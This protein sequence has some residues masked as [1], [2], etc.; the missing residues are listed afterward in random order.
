MHFG[1][2][3]VQIEIFKTS[4]N[5]GR[6]KNIKWI[7]HN[8]S[9]GLYIW[10]EEEWQVASLTDDNQHNKICILLCE[11][12]D[13]MSA[14]TLP[15]FVRQDSLLR[16]SVL[17]YIPITELTYWIILWS[18]GW[19]R[20]QLI[21]LDHGLYRELDNSTRINYASLWKVTMLIQLL[22]WSQFTSQYFNIFYH[23]CL[24]QALV[25]SDEKAIKEYSVKLGAGEDLHAFF[26]G[27]LT[28]K[29]WNSVIDPSVG[30]LILDGNNTDRSEVQVIFV[31]HYFL[32]T[33]GTYTSA[34]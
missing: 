34:N 16:C 18:V 29:P 26:A 17:L 23:V 15:I 10:W 22:F 24:T 11:T 9:I 2:S 3:V 32:L 20:P 30:H 27:V 12:C 31:M 14:I 21:L 7:V 33:V 4:Y 19:K 6:R 28:M 5:P 1:L 8:I 13:L 25:L